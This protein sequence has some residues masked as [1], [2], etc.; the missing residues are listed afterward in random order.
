[1][2]KI[3]LTHMFPTGIC[4]SAVSKRTIISLISGLKKILA[5][6]IYCISGNKITRTFFTGVVNHEGCVFLSGF[7]PNGISLHDLYIEF[8][9]NGYYSE[10][11]G[12]LIFTLNAIIKA[13]KLVYHE[14]G[15]YPSF[16]LN[17]VYIDLDRNLVIFLPSRI[18]DY[19]NRHRMT[20]EKEP[21]TLCTE[22]ISGTE[23]L[24]EKDFTFCI[25]RTLYLFFTKNQPVGELGLFDITSF[26][27][28][29]SRSVADILWN[30]LHGRTGDL[31][32]LQTVLES[33][34]GTSISPPPAR[35][36][37]NR[38]RSY[39]LL[40]YSVSRFL[41]KRKM[42]LLILVLVAA[43]LSY[44][45]GDYLRH[46]DKKDYTLG[47][48]PL[49][50]V[51]L[52]F[53]AVDELNLDLLDAVFYRRAGKKIKDEVSRVYVMTKLEHAFGKRFDERQESTSSDSIDPESP[54]ET[55]GI[56]DLTILQMSNG[57][58]PIF[59]ANYKKF[60][61][62]GET[63]SVYTYRETIYIKQYRDHWYIIK[64][65]RELINRE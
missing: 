54:L 64:T 14:T 39:L 57:D 25:A 49:Q 35:I 55:Y 56:E 30:I 5:E 24:D 50:V 41:A 21:F 28:D 51:E 3:E 65:E 23:Q 34:N 17:S 60:L 47:L 16:Q 40:K 52:Y 31:K 45:I 6:P 53:K 26:V 20:G 36:P 46:R 2:K 33:Y 37:L 44:L 38:R 18:M 12:R 62:A 59:Q 43:V 7:T 48:Q 8:F 32:D 27:P 29:A 4:E 10:L 58:Q 22:N 13:A 19:L 9:L 1:M 11:T 63:T 61:S 15:F 42:L